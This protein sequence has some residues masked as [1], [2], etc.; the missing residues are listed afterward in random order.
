MDWDTF[1]EFRL[2]KKSHENAN[3]VLNTASASDVLGLEASSISAEIARISALLEQ[4]GMSGVRHGY[5]G[6]ADEKSFDAI[7]EAHFQYLT[8]WF[9]HFAHQAFPHLIDLDR[10]IY[11][12]MLKSRK[13]TPFMKSDNTTGAFIGI[14]A[15]FLVAVDLFFRAHFRLRDLGKSLQSPVGTGHC[16]ETDVIGGHA[17]ERALRSAPD[18]SHAVMLQ[19]ESGYIA[20]ELFDPAISDQPPV[21]DA[22]DWLESNLLLETAKVHHELTGR[23]GEFALL[24]PS[25]ESRAAAYLCTVFGIFHEIGHE[26]LAG[27][28]LEFARAVGIDDSDPANAVEAGID[29]L[30][31]SGYTAFV[32]SISTE[33]DMELLVRPIIHPARFTMGASAFF[34]VA[35]ATLFAEW[36]FRGTQN[37]TGGRADIDQAAF[38]PRTGLLQKRHAGLLGYM[39]RYF[40]AGDGGK[41]ADW[42]I[43]A[44]GAALETR[45]V[46]VA[47]SAMLD[48]FLG[49]SST[50]CEKYSQ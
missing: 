5:S 21:A 3:A 20:F 27:C 32:N 30:A 2:W 50:F 38:Q 34:A 12:G 39:Q 1:G 28:E 13:R 26:L 11:A 8:L 22:P 15:G 48:R 7:E 6:A 17:I 43:F 25:A 36:I 33:T 9:M 41:I 35:K 16:V 24:V 42:H 40:L 19:L 37:R 31:Y 45:C 14:P 44:L 18:R 46:E 49:I 10:P 47:L 4:P 23:G 29:L